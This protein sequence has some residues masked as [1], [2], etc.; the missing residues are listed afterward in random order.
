MVDSSLLDVRLE[1]TLHHRLDYVVV[2]RLSSS[3]VAPWSARS[4]WTT[5]RGSALR[6]RGKLGASAYILARH[7]NPA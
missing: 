3:T 5:S 2:Q 7:A 6:S 4:D 1:T